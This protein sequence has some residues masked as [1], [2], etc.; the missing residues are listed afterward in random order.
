MF[1]FRFVFYLKQ[2]ILYN[3]QD[4]NKHAR[5]IYFMP[6]HLMTTK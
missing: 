6:E 5:F 4:C 3:N 2:E 1:F